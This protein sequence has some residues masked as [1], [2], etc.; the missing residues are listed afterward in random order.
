MQS[1]LPFRRL[2]AYVQPDFQENRFDA[3]R[4]LLCGL[5]R[6][7]FFRAH[8]EY[9]RRF[10]DAPADYGRAS[11]GIRNP[12]YYLCRTIRKEEKVAI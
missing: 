6:Y 1:L 4:A 10:R 9:G 11:C 12:Y 7:P 2:L 3:G 5:P 8:S